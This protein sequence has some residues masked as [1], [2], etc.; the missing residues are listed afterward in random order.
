[1]QSLRRLAPTA[2]A[3]QRGGFALQGLAGELRSSQPA[4]LRFIGGGGVPDQ[5]GQPQAGGTK[6]LGTPAN[7]MEVCEMALSLPHNARS[8]HM[9]SMRPFAL[10]R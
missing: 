1:M 8:S 4:A 3:I 6:F 7:Y 10:V 2:G 9:Y 5:W